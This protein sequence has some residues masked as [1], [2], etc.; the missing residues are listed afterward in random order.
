MLTLQV[1]IGYRLI[2]KSWQQIIFFKLK[3]FLTVASCHCRVRLLFQWILKNIQ[4]N[5]INC[6]YFLLQIVHSFIFNTA[7]P[8]FH[9]LHS[10]GY[11]STLS[12]PTSHGNSYII[13]CVEVCM[14]F[15]EKAKTREK[16]RG[17]VNEKRLT[18]CLHR[19]RLKLQS[20]PNQR[21]LQL[22]LKAVYSHSPPFLSS[23]AVYLLYLAKVLFILKSM[24]GLYLCICGLH[25]KSPSFYL[26]LHFHI[27]WFLWTH[28]TTIS[29]FT[30]RRRHIT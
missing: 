22:I 21:G 1:T 28:T 27:Y 26:S 3:R 29:Q 14:V 24:Q 15:S 5:K 19:L 4:I 11:C 6:I 20:L 23:V 13:Q 25:W 2:K 17:G 12:T 16:E 30:N 8:F 10:R 18:C 7:P 9:G